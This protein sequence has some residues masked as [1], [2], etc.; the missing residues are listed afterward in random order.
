[1]STK[2]QKAPV[3]LK[4]EALES[5]E[6][7][8]GNV[9][10]FVQGS[11]L[12]VLG[13]NRDNGVEIRQSGIDTYQVRGL[14]H[15][16]SATTIN[17][18]TG[19][20][21]FNA[22]GDDVFVSLSGGNDRVDVLGQSNGQRSLIKGDLKVYGGSGNDFI[23]MNKV[24]TWGNVLV[25]TGSGKDTTSIDNAFIRGHG[26]QSKKSGYGLT[27]EDHAYKAGDRD[28]VYV[29]NSNVGYST[30]KADLKI[31]LNAGNDQ[32]YLYNTVTSY[33][34]VKTYGGDDYISVSN[35]KV[36]T[37]FGQLHGGPGR[38][39]LRL[40]NNSGVGRGLATSIE[41]FS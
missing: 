5:R 31:D 10:V 27:I 34:N 29:Y 30:Y 39:T 35:C 13:D 4:L 28:L 22:V 20:R 33:L 12:F 23:Y 8:A 41:V 15:G 25:D 40:W 1:M 36:W 11:V 21:T 2:R 26:D 9:S 38:D 24:H 17:G 32:V 37:H 19:T 7:L 18:S 14:H 16:G 3:A 6:V